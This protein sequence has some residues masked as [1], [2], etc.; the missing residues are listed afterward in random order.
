M[1]LTVEWCD[2]REILCSFYA[3][4]DETQTF[5]KVLSLSHQPTEDFPQSPWGSRRQWQMQDEPFVFILVCS[6]F[7][8]R[9]LPQMLFLLSLFLIFDSWTLTF[10]ERSE[11]FTC[12]FGFFCDLL[13][14]RLATPRKVHH[15]SNFLKI[16]CCAVVHWSLRKDSVTF[17]RMRDVND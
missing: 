2:V 12:C 17:S 8:L 13:Y 1:C 5:Q 15:Y 6:G 7:L 16:M 9:T 14:G 4:Q 11:A 10:T 3:R